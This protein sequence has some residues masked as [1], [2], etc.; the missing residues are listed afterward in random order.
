MNKEKEIDKL[1][2]I[3]QETVNGREDCDYYEVAYEIVNAGYGHIPTAL[4][5]YLHS[6]IKAAAMIDSIVVIKQR[7]A[8]KEFAE[9][10]IDEFQ[11]YSQL[12]IKQTCELIDNRAKEYE[13]GE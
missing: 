10:L 13:H 8:V 11:S 2:D 7:E 9:K 1:V 5:A 3:M 6:N 12:G 4:N